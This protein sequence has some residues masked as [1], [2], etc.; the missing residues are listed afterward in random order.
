MTSI[1]KIN[2]NHSHQSA[3]QKKNNSW[4]HSTDLSKK[5]LLQM[6]RKLKVNVLQFKMK[7][8]V[9]LEFTAIRIIGCFWDAVVVSLNI[10]KYASIR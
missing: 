10:C 2:E 6:E 3:S 9:T 4:Q 5:S 7:G 8:I 1:R